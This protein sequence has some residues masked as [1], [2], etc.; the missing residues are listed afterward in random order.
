MQSKNE[1]KQSEIFSF[2]SLAQDLHSFLFSPTPP[3][4]SLSQNLANLTIHEVNI[5]GSRSPSVGTSNVENPITTDAKQ[6][7]DNSQ[8]GLEATV[9]FLGRFYHPIK[10][11]ISS[12]Q[13]NPKVPL[14]TDFF[15]SINP[16]KEKLKRR[17]KWWA[18]RINN[19]DKETIHNFNLSSYALNRYEKSILEKERS[20]CPTH[21]PDNFQLFLDLHRFT[22][23][24]TLKRF[25]AIQEQKTQDIL[26]K[27]ENPVEI[28]QIEEKEYVGRTTQK[29]HL[30]VNRHRANIQ[31]KFLLH[32]FS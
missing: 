20:Y 30:R 9:S 5:E 28:I 18:K 6:L 16:K 32:G 10:N 12:Q 13:T 8:A 23:N 19:G 26:E 21:K 4:P 22:R 29:L 2:I 27:E 14:I 1:W 25:F 24:L 17:K 3:W 7:V 31:N 15:H 11:P